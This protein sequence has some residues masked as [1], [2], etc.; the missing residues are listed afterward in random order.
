MLHLHIKHLN[1][2]DVENTREILCRNIRYYLGGKNIVEV[3]RAF[4]KVIKDDMIL[5]INVLASLIFYFFI[6][7]SSSVPMASR[8]V[9]RTLS[10]PVKYRPIHVPG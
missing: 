2:L 5:H 1:E 9:S 7:Q 8:S 4:P 6:A 10:L 3:D